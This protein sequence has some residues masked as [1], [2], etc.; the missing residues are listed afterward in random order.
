MV[1]DYK[2]TIYLKDREINA[3]AFTLEEYMSLISAKQAG[4]SREEIR[5]VVENCTGIDILDD[6]P[7][8]VAEYIVFLLWVNSLGKVNYEDVYVCS[9]GNEIHTPMNFNH[10]QI[11]REI[12]HTETVGGIKLHFKPAL[13]FSET[14]K[15][16]T[17]LDRMDYLI[18]DGEQVFVDSLSDE[19]V[20]DLQSVITYELVEKVCDKIMS[21][22]IHLGIPIRCDKCN[23][24]HVEELNSLK[25]FMRIVK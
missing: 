14:D 5:K 9:C 6:V 17:F 24:Y 21:P 13:I 25:D 18:V 3:R 7:K 23:K 1:T 2:F 4:T 12:E 20:D 15:I 11:D 8:A 22:T 10:I 19:E 16:H